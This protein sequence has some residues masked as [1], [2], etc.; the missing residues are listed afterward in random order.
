MANHILPK[1]RTLIPSG[2]LIRALANQGPRFHCSNC[3]DVMFVRGATGLCPMCFNDRTPSKARDHSCEVGHALVLAGV[4]D[5]P[6]IEGLESKT[7]FQE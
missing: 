2:F 3:G 5:D 4:L 6:R 1:C 7:P